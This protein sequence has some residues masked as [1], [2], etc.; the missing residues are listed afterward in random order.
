MCNM[1]PASWDIITT[2]D[3]LGGANVVTDPLVTRGYL[4]GGQGNSYYIKDV[5]GMWQWLLPLPNTTFLIIKTMT[6]HVL[7]PSSW[8]HVRLV[9]Q[10]SAHVFLIMTDLKLYFRMRFA[11]GKQLN[12]IYDAFPFSMRYRHMMLFHFIFQSDRWPQNTSCAESW[13]AIQ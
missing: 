10:V 13:G 4:F 3:T 9:C 6:L 7:I 11:S 2:W 5:F 8:I 12:W 1:R